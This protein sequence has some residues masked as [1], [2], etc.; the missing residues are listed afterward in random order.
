MENSNHFLTAIT[1]IPLFG[2]LLILCVPSRERK[3]IKTIAACSSFGAL[4]VA[5]WM[6]CLFDRAHTGTGTGVAALAS[7]MQFVEKI[8][9]IPAYKIQYYMGVDGLSFPM[10]LL[11]ALLSL[12]IGL[13]L[14]LMRRTVLGWMGAAP[15]VLP[16]GSV[17]LAITTLAIT[18]YFLLLTYIAVFQALGDMRTPLAIMVVVN[19]VLAQALAARLGWNRRPSPALSELELPGWLWPGVAV[20]AV[21]VLA[22]GIIGDLGWSLLIVLVVPYLFLGLA[23]VHVVVRRWSRPGLALAA[24]YGAMI[25]LGWPILLVLLLGFVEDWAHLRRR[26]L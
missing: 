22:G 7:S 2:A 3:I 25:L 26:W 11:S 6:L 18:P 21:L 15:E 5:C 23:L 10:V 12:T 16:A 1:F 8:N 13:P 19:G 4:V 24:I 14:W 20:A 17:Y 9:W